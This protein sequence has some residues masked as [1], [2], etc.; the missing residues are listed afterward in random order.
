MK[1]VILLLVFIF[2][3][4]C[5]NLEA[6]SKVGTIDIDFLLMSMPEIKTVQENL[7]DYGT[8]LDNQLNEKMTDYQSKLD[9]YNTNVA[10][11]TETQKQEKQTEIFALEEDISKFRQNG[12]QLIRIREDELKR[13]LYQK[14]ATSLEKIAQAE[15]YSQILNVNEGSDVVFIN[16]DFDITLKVAQ[17][18]GLETEE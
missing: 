3:G 5:N 6:Q 12:M 16:P 13:P 2:M 1:K 11:L 18:L 14:I 4:V 7:K 15:G 10:S 9:D 17:D 8:T